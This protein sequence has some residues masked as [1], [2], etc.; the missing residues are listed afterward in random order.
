MNVSLLAVSIGNTRTHIGTFVEGKLVAT[1]DVV[2]EQPEQLEGALRRG[3]EALRRFGAP[4]IV[5]SVNPAVTERLAALVQRTLPEA[6]LR[7]VES[8]LPIPVG[9]QLDPESIVGEDRLLNAAAAYDL[10]KQACVVI[11]A[12]TAITIDF[13]DGAGTFHGG[14]IGP[15]AQMMLR[16]LHQHT[17]LLPEVEFEP[18]AEPIGHNTQQ[19][20][21]TA[22]FHGLRGMVRELVEQYA[23]VAGSYPMVVATGGN[24]EVLFKGFDLVERII[25][26]LALL[27][28][29]VTLQ[30][31]EDSEE[32][33]A[34]DEGE[35]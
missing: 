4:V 24:A 17:A 21:L 15:G 27:G 10:L 31:S 11:D 9:R 30:K 33:D 23:E 13:V 7:R 14:A 20:M 29:A 2:N 6:A 8:A 16:S 5:G 19:A 35:N 28:L 26:D 22:V 25:P 3:Y 34:D 32:A 1:Q 12:G 18:P